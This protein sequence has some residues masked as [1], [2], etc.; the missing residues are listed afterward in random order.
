MSTESISTIKTSFLTVIVWIGLASLFLAPITSKAVEIERFERLYTKHG[1]SQ[2]NVQSLYCDQFGYLWI[3]TM[4]G[5]NRYDGYRFK[6]YESDPQ[7]ANSLTQN[8][9]RKIFEDERNFIWLETNELCLHYMI[10]ETGE[11]TTFPYYRKETTDTKSHITV[12]HQYDKNQIWLGSFRTGLY[13]L[14]YDS[15]TGRYNSTQYF[16]PSDKKETLRINF[17][18]R[19]VNGDLFIGTPNEL[20]F[21]SAKSIKAQEPIFKLIDSGK[22]Y[23]S[24][25]VD[26][27]VLWVATSNQGLLKLEIGTNKVF[28]VPDFDKISSIRITND[29][30][31]LILG[32]PD[33][34]FV[35]YNTKTG[36]TRSYSSGRHTPLYSYEDRSG[37]IWLRSSQS[38]MQRIDRNTFESKSFNTLPPN[39]QPM[40]DDDATSFFED[41]NNNLWISS[42]G[43]GL[44]LYDRNAD[45]LIS[46]W[47]DPNNINSLSSN[48]V[49][50]VAEDK[51]GNIWVG[52]AHS[53]GG[54]NKMIV[55]N[56]SLTQ[57]KINKKLSSSD[58]ENL[59]RS[60][61]LDN[62]GMLWVGNK[63]GKI[64]V[65][66]EEMNM[67]TSFKDVDKTKSAL[68]GYSA[69][70]MTQDSKGFLWIGT[71]GG[72]IS[73]STKPIDKSTSYNDIKFINY[74][75]DPD[76]PMS[77][78]N[79]FVYT[80]KEDTYGQM[81]VGTYSKGI[82]RVL[83][84]TE[85]KLTCRNYE[86]PEYNLSTTFVRNIMI[87]KDQNL[88]VA[89]N[90]GLNVAKINS[91][92]DI[93]RFRNFL[94]KI[95]DDTSL[96]YN[97]VVHIYQDSR[98]WIWF[99]TFGR[100]VDYIKSY[101]EDS[102]IVF[103]HLTSKN[104][105][106]ND[107]VY[108][109]VEDNSGDMWFSTERGLSKYSVKTETVK[110]FGRNSGIITENFC[111]NAVEKDEKGNLFFGNLRGF[112]KVDPQHISQRNY[113]PNIVIT[114]LLVNNREIDKS[115][116]EVPIEG[117]LDL[118]RSIKLNYKQSNI[119]I[120]FAALDFNDPEVLHYKYKLEPFD[121]D[122]IETI[123]NSRT[124]TYTNLN[125]G[126]YTFRVVSTT[127]EGIWCDN[128]LT[129]V[130]TVTPSFWKTWWFYSLVTLL[131]IIIFVSI[132]KYREMEAEKTR[133]ELKKMVDIRTE[134]I[135]EQKKHIEIKN[136]ELNRANNVKDRF[137]N[138]VA[139]DMKNPVSAFNQ[140][141]EMLDENYT[142]MTEEDRIKLIKYT[143]KSAT[144][145]LELLEDLLMWARSQNNS[146]EYHFGYVNISATIKSVLSSTE[147]LLANKNLEVENDFISPVYV[148]CDE[149]SVRTI[150]RNIITNAIKFSYEGDKI[151][152]RKD[153]IGDFIKVS[154]E[155]NGV[156]MTEDVQDKLFK[157]G[158]KI[159]SVGTSGEQGTGLGL[160]ICY[161]FVKGN[162]GK[163]GVKSKKDAGTVFW[164]TLPKDK[165]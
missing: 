54:L 36:E 73:V 21:V 124:A 150:L 56:P 156:G 101:H 159:T 60:L 80:I 141:A 140:L 44:S 133:I 64:C 108:A 117:Q 29:K 151:I 99:A 68:S 8:R 165:I 146:I 164:F 155:D 118:A 130:I 53:N 132:V 100:G 2:N 46:Y 26:D 17:I 139:H 24:T 25:A 78:N 148:F 88:W 10:R 162:G 14:V 119:S 82:N 161:E 63:A 95:N 160:Y 89:T 13:Y 116:S 43:A 134:E 94:S 84:R 97:D 4:N 86:D 7:K 115:S 102:S 27:S 3:G 35:L 154:I 49:L 69:Y 47:H 77:L 18:D 66:D 50:C 62:N 72:G 45:S 135:E 15:I 30:S 144:S 22:N 138:I 157:I 70:C 39:S 23:I 131:L 163:I 98:G 65:Y 38:F 109:I 103:N 76:D 58:D 83:S 106:I 52:T 121:K 122:W 19:A 31:I 127:C 74:R 143:H 128:E 32:C 1:L 37:I 145:I 67:I 92:K 129:T 51:S 87:D 136:E 81:W 104:G 16:L 85:K 71:K 75:N 41:S 125:P 90:F 96:G 149:M 113:K 93:R 110:N 34:K 114:K 147:L 123:G 137:F 28:Q 61:F 79:N 55:A 59:V 12:F 40:A 11:F 105:L 158:E 5:L 153:S 6:V 111:E 33:Y 120:E 20:Y 9:V 91:D 48:Y 107:A 152:I 142:E 112:V 126:T 57:I 42:Q